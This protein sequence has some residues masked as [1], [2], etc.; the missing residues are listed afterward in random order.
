MYTGLI[1]KTRKLK[2]KCYLTFAFLICMPTVGFYFF[3]FF[4]FFFPL[5]QISVVD[6]IHQLQEH[7]PKI[8]NQKQQQ[9]LQHPISSQHSQ[10]SSHLIQQQ[11]KLTSSGI[12]DADGYMSYNFQANNQVKKFTH[13]CFQMILIRI[14]L[15]STRY[16][17]SL[18]FC[19]AVLNAQLFLSSI[20][21]SQN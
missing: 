7:Q 18:D 1:F 3:F 6:S 14:T 10:N 5:K 9:C 12:T 20:N 17:C 21:S 11:D 16:I 2:S 19:S 13:F 15:L 4:L 8:D